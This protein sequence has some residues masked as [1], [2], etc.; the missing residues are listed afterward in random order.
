MTTLLKEVI[1]TFKAVLS[2]TFGGF[3]TWF[4][5]LA[6]LISFD[7][8]FDTIERSKT[9]NL[10]TS[11]RIFIKLSIKKA[12]IFLIIGVA[13]IVDKLL[14]DGNAVTRLAVM[15]YFI[16]GEL[17]NISENAASIG[18]TLPPSLKSAID[19]LKKRFR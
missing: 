6:I 13:T 16:V 3:D 5:Y 7:V 17:I 1:C 19:A 2:R 8:L 18:I 11:L 10:L 14:S 9:S 15:G 4:V 12:T